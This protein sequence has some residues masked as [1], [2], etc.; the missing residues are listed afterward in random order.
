MKHNVKIKDK[1]WEEII[2]FTKIR[3]AGIGIEDIIMRL[4]K[5]K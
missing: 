3:K 2:D 1:K 5:I 4:K